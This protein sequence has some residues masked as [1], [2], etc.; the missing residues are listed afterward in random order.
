MSC[1]SFAQNPAISFLVIQS[2]RHPITYFPELA[3][4]CAV[5]CMQSYPTLWDPMDCSPQG[6]SVHQIV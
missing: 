4:Y 2:K 1:N 3:Y 5:C 6:S